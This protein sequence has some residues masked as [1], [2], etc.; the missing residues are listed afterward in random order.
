MTKVY[1]LTIMDGCR[2]EVMAIASGY[3]MCCYPGC[4]PFVASLEELKL[5]RIKNE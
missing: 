1:A 2:V 3:A 4:P 5:L